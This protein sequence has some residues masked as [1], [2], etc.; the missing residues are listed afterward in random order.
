[1]P[2]TGLKVSSRSEADAVDDVVAAVE[3]HAAD[4][5]AEG[6]ALFVGVAADAGDGGHADAELRAFAEGIDLHEEAGTGGSGDALAQLAAGDAL[7]PLLVAGRSLR[8]G[9]RRRQSGEQDGQ[10]AD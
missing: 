3:G 10:D 6:R 9:R 7:G 5:E 8:Q 2:W 1:M 4:E